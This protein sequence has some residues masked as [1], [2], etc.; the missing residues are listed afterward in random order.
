MP[1]SQLPVREAF[2][3]GVMVILP[4]PT[5]SAFM[6]AEV[7]IIFPERLITILL[8]SAGLSIEARIP[9][10][11]VVPLFISTPPRLGLL[12]HMMPQ[13]TVSPHPSILIPPT[14]D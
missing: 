7:A 6:S 1:N 3:P 13:P 5:V 4:L 8:E 11:P 14:P 9:E 12:G 2:D 10:Q